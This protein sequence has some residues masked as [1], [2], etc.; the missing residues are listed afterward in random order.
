M[1]ADKVD[2]DSNGATSSC[3]EI[4]PLEKPD[5]SGMTARSL[6]NEVAFENNEDPV[7]WSS[8]RKWVYVA[9]L[10]WM[11]FVMYVYHSGI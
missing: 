2:S 10:S 1:S 8:V 4:P 6:M 5:S 3:I 7:L 11:A 9:L